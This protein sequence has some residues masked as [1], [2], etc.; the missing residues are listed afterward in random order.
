MMNIVAEVTKLLFEVLIDY[1]T[2]FS[3]GHTDLLN[4]WHSQYLYFM[5]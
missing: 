1:F 5:D 3:Y 4:D 2:I